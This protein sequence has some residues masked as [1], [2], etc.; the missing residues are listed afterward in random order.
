[1]LGKIMAVDTT[2]AYIDRQV[3]HL[4]LAMVFSDPSDRRTT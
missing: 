3:H 2:N 4:D 1:M